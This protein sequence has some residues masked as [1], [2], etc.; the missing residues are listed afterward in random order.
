DYY[1]RLA[2][3]FGGMRLDGTTAKG[4]ETGIPANPKPWSEKSL[5]FSAFIYKGSPLLSQTDVSFQTDP[6]CITLPSPIVDVDSTLS[7]E[8]KFG[9]YGG[10]LAWNFLDV[11]VHAGATTRTDKSPFLADP[12]DTDVKSKNRFGE[13]DWVAYP[14]LVPAVRWE[15]F[16]VA[17]EK[18]DKA[19]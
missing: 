13:V 16:D 9:L 8:D 19:T 7:Q 10:D 15:S 4:G 12:T 2:Y 11:I 18:T 6:T 5:T 1:G 17:G 14:W 3:K